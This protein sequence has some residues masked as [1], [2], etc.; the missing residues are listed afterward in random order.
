MFLVKVITGDTALMNSDDSLKRPPLKSQLLDFDDYE[1]EE[2]RVRS[3]PVR[4]VTQRMREAK[5]VETGT[6]IKHD[7]YDSCS[8][9]TGGSRVFITYS[10]PK[11]FPAYLISYKDQYGYNAWG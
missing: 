3:H 8:G 2:T 6:K 9:F 7:R 1:G 4:L 5:R 10:S 11:Q